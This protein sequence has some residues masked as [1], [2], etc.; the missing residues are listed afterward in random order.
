[1]AQ[2]MIMRINRHLPLIIM[3]L[4]RAKKV[5]KYDAE[6]PI[7]LQFFIFCKFLPKKVGF[8]PDEK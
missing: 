1:M 8:R 2:H 7:F 6:F 3:V 4:K 5:P